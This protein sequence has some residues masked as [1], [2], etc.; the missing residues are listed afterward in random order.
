MRKSVLIL[1]F[2]WVLANPA[3]CC[4]CGWVGPDGWLDYPPPLTR[5]EA[6]ESLAIF[7]GR[8]ESVEWVDVPLKDN[9]TT[10]AI[11]A[12]FAVEKMWRGRHSEHLAVFSTD[13]CAILFE[14]GRRYLVFA[15]RLERFYR[16]RMGLPRFSLETDQCTRT[17]GIPSVISS[18]GKE[19]DQLLP[20]WS[21]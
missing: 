14:E 5:S 3:F 18:L 7:S 15:S 21:P 6:R 12:V 8:V 13:G 11:K 4:S 2:S 1:L 20:A 16:K 9:S 17:T 10:F 19:L